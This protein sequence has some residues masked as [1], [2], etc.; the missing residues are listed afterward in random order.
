MT[1]SPFASGPG[2]KKTCFGGKPRCYSTSGAPSV[3]ISGPIRSSNSPLLTP[4]LTEA[5]PEVQSLSSAGLTQSHRAASSGTHPTPMSNPWPILHH[6]Q[7]PPRSAVCE[8]APGSVTG[9]NA[10]GRRSGRARRPRPWAG[11][12]GGL[13]SFTWR[14]LSELTSRGFSSRF[15]PGELTPAWAL[16]GAPLSPRHR[17]NTDASRAL[18]PEGARLRHSL[19]RRG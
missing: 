19:R 13:S 5:E 16:L 1:S 14:L 17:A 10:G 3:F 18:D 15:C 11:S 4:H 9:P 8:E 12:E 7:P 6:S 2:G